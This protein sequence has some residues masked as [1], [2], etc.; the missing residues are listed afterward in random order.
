MCSHEQ[1]FE[2]MPDC[3]RY[4]DLQHTK[5][6][7]AIIWN[8]S[9]RWD[10]LTPKSISHDKLH[11]HQHPTCAHMGCLATIHETVAPTNLAGS[12]STTFS[13]ICQQLRMARPAYRHLL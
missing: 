7:A 4:F 6:T 10:H 3:H 8:G 11:Y 9:G 13:A 12:G 1:K 2:E 5:R